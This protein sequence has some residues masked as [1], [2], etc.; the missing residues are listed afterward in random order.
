MLVY[1]SETTRYTSHATGAHYAGAWASPTAADINSNPSN[2]HANKNKIAA[3]KDC[4][5]YS[6]IFF[7]IGTNIE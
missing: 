2:K 5:V 4:V 7:Q 6:K 3:N 1:T